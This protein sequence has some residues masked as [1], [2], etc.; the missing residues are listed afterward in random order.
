MRDR[1]G[2]IRASVLGMRTLTTLLI[3]ACAQPSSDEAVLPPAPA[4][5]ELRLPPDTLIFREHLSQRGAERTGNWWARIDTKGCYTEAHNTWLWVL[6]PE[7]EYSSAWDLHWNG[8]PRLEPWFCLEPGQLRRLERALRRV[9]EWG[10]VGMARGP[11]DRWTTVIDG[12][13]TS[14]VLPIRANPGGFDPLL[15]TLREIAAEGVWGLS[16]E[17]APDSDGMAAAGRP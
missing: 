5:P 16:R 9:D 10:G 12:R 8:S 13:T 15:G 3:L 7:I 1:V 17:P 4:L 14:I 2:P 11:V 6:D